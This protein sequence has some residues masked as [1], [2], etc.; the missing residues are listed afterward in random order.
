MSPGSEPYSASEHFGYTFAPAEVANY[1]VTTGPDTVNY[2]NGHVPSVTPTD[3]DSQSF[4]DLAQIITLSLHDGL[5]RTTAELW[6]KVVSLLE[7]LKSSIG[8]AGTVLIWGWDPMKSEA[9]ARFFKRVGASTWSLDDWITYARRNQG[10]LDRVATAIDQARKKMAPLITNF[11]TNYVDALERLAQGKQGN[12]EYAYNDHIKSKRPQWADGNNPQNTRAALDDLEVLKEQYTQQARQIFKDL[13]DEFMANY[14][15]SSG[16]NEGHRFQGPIEAVNPMNG[17]IDKFK[18]NLGGGGP[19]ALPTGPAGRIAQLRAELEQRLAQERAAQDAA[20]EALRRL[21]ERQAALR[22]NV[23]L[24]P[25][26]VLPP[27]VALPPRSVLPPQQFPGRPATPGKLPDVAITEPGAAPSGVHKGLGSLGGRPDAVTQGMRSRGGPES[28][29]PPPPGTPGRP[30][31]PPPPPN[32]GLRGRQRDKNNAEPDRPRPGTRPEREDYLADT[33]LAPG[34][35]AARLA[36]GG[37]P[38]EPPTRMPAASLPGRSGRPSRG[39]PTLRPQDLAG[40]RRTVDDGENELMPSPSMLRPDLT[41]RRG[42]PIDLGLA[43][44]D[45]GANAALLGTRGVPAE[46]PAPAFP[47]D[48]TAPAPGDAGPDSELWNVAMPE[49]IETPVE[50]KP[51]DPRASGQALGTG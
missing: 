34:A 18:Q 51:A 39:E 6:G 12:T 44:A 14:W 15:G 9:A 21:V 49:P 33:P 26:V 4:T 11:L 48:A 7:D 23:P 50:R 27:Q 36:A 17:I 46:V 25:P 47:A 10:A 37:P 30:A 20:D 41:G 1:G 24:Q 8:T 29:P 2:Y 31:H 22:P 42:G 43:G 13:S 16:L 3:W 45:V 38:V 40:R 35:M 5:Y 28:F 19:V 32:P